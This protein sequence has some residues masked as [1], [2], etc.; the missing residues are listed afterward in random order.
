MAIVGSGTKPGIGVPA[1]I[2]PSPQK[3][4]QALHLLDVVLG[5]GVNHRAGLETRKA[6]LEVLLDDAKATFMNSYQIDWLR[7]RLRDTDLRLAAAGA[8]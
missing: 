4:V 1:L 8:F 7:Y 3:P 2:S 5:N 6:A